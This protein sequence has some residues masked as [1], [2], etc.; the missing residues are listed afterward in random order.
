VAHVTLHAI[1]S[2]FPPTEVSG[3][4]GGKDPISRK[5]LE[6][7][8][9]RFDVE[10]EIL[11]FIINGVDR[12]VRILE[13]KAQSIAGEIVKVLWKTHVPLKH[14]RSLLGKLQHAAQIFPAAKGM[15]FPL[16]KATKGK[17][18]KEIGLGKHIEAHAM[19]LNL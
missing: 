3:H 16:N 8:D 17:P 5:K 15:L 14:F 4:V 10:K 11:R 6:K 2:I 9:A 13:V 18:K 1:H 19:L 7:G 12:T